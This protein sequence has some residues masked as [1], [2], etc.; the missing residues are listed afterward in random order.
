MKL[1]DI[2]VAYRGIPQSPGWA[3][4]DSVCRA[5]KKCGH[6]AHPYGKFYSHPGP[7]EKGKG[8]CNIDLGPAP[9]HIDFILYLE[10]NDVDDQ[11]VELK[12]LSIP[13]AYWEFDTAIHKEF[14]REFIRHM[15]FKHVFFGNYKVHDAEKKT[16]S[17]SWLPYAA[18]TDLFFPTDVVEKTDEI[19]MIGS[20]FQPRVFWCQERGI[21]LY[22]NLYREGYRNKL[23]SLRAHAHMFDSGGDGLLVMRPFETFACRTCYVTEKENLYLEL[24]GY[25]N[26]RE[27]YTFEEYSSANALNVGYS[28]YLKTIKHHTYI[29]RC[30]KIV[31][32]ME[33][34]L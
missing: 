30:K 27:Y 22:S 6:R 1:L 10:C 5:L 17:C 34:Y 7:G 33:E 20:A 23:Q 24:L 2:L 25:R 31:K 13:M 19:A 14:S 8:L 3:T 12:D 32:T 11:Y 26:R 15:G 18:D 28:A 29:E 21:K 9:E 16:M 4:G